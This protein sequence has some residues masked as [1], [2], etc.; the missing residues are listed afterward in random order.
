MASLI[1]SIH[2]KLKALWNGGE[3]THTKVFNCTVC[4]AA[5]TVLFAEDVFIHKDKIPNESIKVK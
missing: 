3:V 4:A 5:I 1:N 2:P